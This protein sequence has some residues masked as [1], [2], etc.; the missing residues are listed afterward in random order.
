MASRGSESSDWAWGQQTIKSVSPTGA[1]VD[2]RL[3]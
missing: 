1:A 3:E 2:L